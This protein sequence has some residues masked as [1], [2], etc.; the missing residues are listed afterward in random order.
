M[1]AH[2]KHAWRASPRLGL[3]MIAVSV[4]GA[5]SH[6]PASMQVGRQLPAKEVEALF[7]GK[8]VTSRNLKS[9]TVSVSRYTRDGRV[10]QQREG[11]QR[12]GTWRVLSDGRIC[13]RMELEDESCRWVRQ[14][15]NGSYQKY[16]SN[17]PFA[18]PVITYVNLWAPSPSVAPSRAAAAD[19]SSPSVRQVQAR[20]KQAGFDPGPIDGV[21]GRATLAAWNR[22]QVQ[23]GLPLTNRMDAATIDKLSR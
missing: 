21:W 11:Q 2:F 8:S 16:R 6:L 5:C 20:L 15:K 9:G 19:T 4:L 13:L 7:S 1:H 14:E 23:A 3:S 12:T 17:K 22:F 10:L 18:T